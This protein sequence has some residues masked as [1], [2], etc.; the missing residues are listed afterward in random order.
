[1]LSVVIAFALFREVLS[2]RNK[3]FEIRHLVETY[4]YYLTNIIV[5]EM[6]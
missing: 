2:N 3:R 6:T 1:M 4:K 5:K